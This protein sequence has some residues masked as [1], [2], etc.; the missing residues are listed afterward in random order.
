MQYTVLTSAYTYLA[1]AIGSVT[2]S[3]S[4]GLLPIALAILTAAGTLYFVLLGF[5]VIRGII[6]SPLAELGM[7][8]IKF[9]LVVAL[10]GATGFTGTVISTANGLP[11]AL[12]S[13]GG[14]TPIT[15]PGRAMDKYFW[16]A[17]KLV[18]IVQNKWAKDQADMTGSSTAAGIVG[19][20]LGSG[21]ANTTATLMK[22]SQAM[23]MFVEEIVESIFLAIT[24]LI[25]GIS[26]T[27]GFVIYIF[28]LFALDV[29]LALTPV[30]IACTLFAQSRWIFQG[31][32]SQLLNYLLLMVVVAI[33]TAMVMGLNTSIMN[34]IT[35]VSTTTGPVGQVIAAG[36][37]GQSVALASTTEV[38]L[39]CAAVV[40]VYILGTLFFFQAPAISA[41]IVGGAPS[42][43][44]NFL[45]VAANQVIG[46]VARGGMPRVATSR[47][48]VR[49]GS[50]SRGN[51]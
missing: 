4:N 34:D 13:V 3:Y 11:A 35:G 1:T 28:A 36:T 37:G 9:G 49:G 19:S 20:I 5:M 18:A 14:G 23:N 47:A 45:A 26:A 44:H 29:V 8:A 33:V 12:I 27:I 2:S 41:G 38:I 7:S 17:E 48:S 43:G 22:P 30:A 10:L 39:A 21:A 51:G 25:A 6:A 46:R 42:G 15:N 50:I 32:L 40:I 24:L 31:W 16:N